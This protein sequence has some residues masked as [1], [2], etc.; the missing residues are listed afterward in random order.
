MT[1]R[2]VTGLLAAVF[3]LS[4]LVG[5]SSRASENSM[6]GIKK[7]GEVSFAM[8]GGYPPF[9]FRDEG[10]NLVGFDVDIA[11]EVAKRLGVKLKPVTTAWDGI[12]EGLTGGRYDGILGS[13]AITPERLERVDFSD[14]YYLDGSQLLVRAGSNI[15]STAD[16]KDASVA[17]VTGT[18]FADDAKKISG[19]KEVKSFEDDNQTLSELKNQRE[20]GRASCRERV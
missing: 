7:R 20:I 6:E 12:L 2:W 19:I 5:C 18:T 16:L 14:P 1:K 9:N 13:M 3:A 15:T 11:G 4:A 17:L 8:S 10:G